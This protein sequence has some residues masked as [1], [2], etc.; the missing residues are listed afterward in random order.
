MALAV[1][2]V[3]RGAWSAVRFEWFRTFSPTH[4]VGC[5]A[6]P[7]VGPPGNPDR[8]WCPVPFALRDGTQ[9]GL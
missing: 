2:V 8:G 6:Q 5:V 3:E 9:E 4:A 1:Q 7:R